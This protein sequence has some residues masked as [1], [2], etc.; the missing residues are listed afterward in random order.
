[1]MA[2]HLRLSGV[3]IL[4]F[5]ATS[6]KKGKGK[7]EIE[8]GERKK[9][10]K[11]RRKWDFYY[12]KYI[13]HAANTTAIKLDD[14]DEGEDVLHALFAEMLELEVDDYEDDDHVSR[15]RSSL[16]GEIGHD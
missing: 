8:K 5:M 14:D 13:T 16:K 9:R 3:P 11:G 4:F 10:K 7:K 1:M 15:I 12:L 2:C 6:L